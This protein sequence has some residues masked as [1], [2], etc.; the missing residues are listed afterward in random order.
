MALEGAIAERVQGILPVTWDA[1][2]RDPRFGDALLQAAIDTA[3]EDITG[4]VVDVDDE[5]TYPLIVIDFIA[6]IAAMEIIPAGIDFWMNEPT[7]ESSTGTNEVHSFVDRADKLKQQREELLK[8]TRARAAEIASL[9]GYSRVGNRR[10]P[11][12]NT[13]DDEF[14]TPSPQEFPRPYR[15]TERS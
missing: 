14:L 13:M 7:A 4:I 15:I 8:Q 9:L 12:L 6:K 10:V 3:K 1:L 2:S 11:L 5:A